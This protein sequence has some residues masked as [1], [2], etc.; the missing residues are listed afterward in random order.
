M[1]ER[2]FP[3][4]MGRPEERKVKSSPP[5]RAAK[6]RIAEAVAQSRSSKLKS[7]RRGHPRICEQSLRHVWR[8]KGILRVFPEVGRRFFKAFLANR[9]IG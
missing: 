7:W 6:K 3:R 9:T 1:I 4:R 5:R 2:N 8:L